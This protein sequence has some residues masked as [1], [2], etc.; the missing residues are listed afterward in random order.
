MT[1][2]KF[3][4]NLSSSSTDYSDQSSSEEEKKSSRKRAKRTA[5]NSSSTPKEPQARYFCPFCDAL[6]PTK[7]LV[8]EH[9]SEHK[10]A[11]PIQC[12]KCDDFFYHLD[13]LAD[14]QK[15]KHNTIRETEPKPCKICGKVL[16]GMKQHMRRVHNDP[17]N[18][19]CKYCNSH[20]RYAVSLKRHEKIHMEDEEFNCQ[21]CSMK[22]IGGPNLR[23]HIIREC[24]SLPFKCDECERGFRCKSFLDSH[25][26][27]KHG[28]PGRFMCKKC[29]KTY[30]TKAGIDKHNFCMHRDKSK[31]S[32]LSKHFTCEKCGMA[33]HL[34]HQ[35]YHHRVIHE[36]KHGC[37]VCG[38]KFSRPDYLKKHMVIH[39][40]SKS[41]LCPK[42]GKTFNREDN[43]KIH[44]KSKTGCCNAKLKTGGSGNS[45][46]KAKSETD[47]GDDSGMDEQ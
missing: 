32:D 2:S 11:I 44:M 7:L 35:L 25:N 8:N 46:Q 23:N 36:K 17:I 43:L 37:N 40:G 4:I 31:D 13:T 47:M 15:R 22:I 41:F 14:H 30:P 10:G 42:C 39:D 33:F 45:K 28:A 16:I 24:R 38:K 6:F 20:F 29:N 12:E 34:P 27:R 26:M 19:N 18:L 1:T 3:K 5:K 9:I 21:Y